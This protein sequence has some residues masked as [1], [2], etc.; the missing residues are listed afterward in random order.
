MCVPVDDGAGELRMSRYEYVPSCWSSTCS[1]AIGWDDALQTYFAQVLDHSIGEDDDGV[2]VWLGGMPP[3]YSGLDEMMQA[4]NGRINGKLP[5]VI[6]P[7]EL[8]AALMKDKER[9]SQPS[10]RNGRKP[11]KSEPV[12]ALELFPRYRRTEDE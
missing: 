1:F 4:V 11:R 2:T 5:A 12:F 9:G 7:K 3:H 8:R 10:R 6:L